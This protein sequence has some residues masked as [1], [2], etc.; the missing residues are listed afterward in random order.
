MAEDDPDTARGRNSRSLSRD[1]EIDETPSSPVS[2]SNKDGQ[3]RRTSLQS[4]G[5]GSP[6]LSPAK[7]P[8]D[9]EPYPN[10]E[11]QPDLE[12]TH[13]E[14]GDSKTLFYLFVLTLSIGG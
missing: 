3:R 1:V 8:Q 10:G 9:D 13:N 4:Q 5:E 7:Q 12:S 2:A 11:S 6:L 14:E